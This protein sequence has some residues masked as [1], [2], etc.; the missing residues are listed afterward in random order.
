MYKIISEKKYS[1]Y[2]HDF[3]VSY[4]FNLPEPLMYLLVFTFYFELNRSYKASWYFDV[5]TFTIGCV[6]IPLTCNWSY[7]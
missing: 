1:F 5:R 4:Y 3:V 6:Y 2:K 7:V